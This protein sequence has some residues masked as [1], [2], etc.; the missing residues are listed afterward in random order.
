MSE[1]L[2]AVAIIE[3]MFQMRRKSAEAFLNGL[4]VADVGEHMIKQWKL[5]ILGGH[6]QACHRHQ[7]EQA[8]GF[9]RHGLAAGVRPA[10][11]QDPPLRVQLQRQWN[12]PHPFGTKQSF[13][14]RVPSAL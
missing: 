13:E 9:Q 5:G 4:R 2:L 12:D 14:Q 11:H 6:G 10:D 3:A 7:S 8:H 1:S